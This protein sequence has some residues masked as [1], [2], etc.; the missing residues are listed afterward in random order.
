M[1]Y[2]A[3]PVVENL[4]GLHWEYVGLQGRWTCM[5]FAGCRLGYAMVDDMLFMLGSCWGIC[6]VHRLQN[7][8]KTCRFGVLEAKRAHCYRSFADAPRNS[9]TCRVFHVRGYLV[10]VE[11]SFCSLTVLPWIVC[12]SCWWLTVF[13]SYSSATCVTQ[14][15]PICFSMALTIH[16]GGLNR[17]TEGHRLYRPHTNPIFGLCICGIGYMAVIAFVGPKCPTKNSRNDVIPMKATD[18]RMMLPAGAMLEAS[19]SEVSAFQV[20]VVLLCATIPVLYWWFVIVPFKRRDLAISKARGPMKTYLG[21]LATTP[22][23]ERKQEKWF[24]DKYLRQGKFIEPRA[25]EGLTEVV[26]VME[27]EMQETLPGGG[28]WSFDNPIFV[29]LVMLLLFCMQQVLFHDVIQI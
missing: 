17:L 27:D 14:S 20:I 13:A 1:P 12:P 15:C 18:S 6:I 22:P 24:Y 2:K 9:D 4:L 7:F 10:A 21:E 23:E 5:E 8:W 29:C 26:Q 19:N 28:F 16:R 11:N 3:E 25:S